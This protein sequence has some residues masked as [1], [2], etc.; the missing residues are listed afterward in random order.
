MAADRVLR[1]LIEQGGPIDPATDRRGSRPDPY[2]A[3]A[4]A[5]VGQQLSVKA[6]ASIWGKLL[7]QFGGGRRR[8]NSSWLVGRRSCRRRASPAPRSPSCATSPSASKTAASTS[9]GCAGFPT[10]TWSRS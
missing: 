8:P 9:S 10:R 3:L 5:I 1:A 4:R 7:E 6:A 2:Q